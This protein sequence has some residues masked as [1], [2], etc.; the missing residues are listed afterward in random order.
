MSQSAILSLAVLKVNWET[1]GKDYLENFVPFLLECIRL[2][3]DDLVSLPDLQS[4]VKKRFDLEIPQHAIE[5]LLRRMAKRGY[6]QTRRK[7]Y[8]RK[9]DLLD[10]TGFREA[11]QR[12]LQ[13]HDELLRSLISFCHTAHGVGWTEKDAEEALE[14]YLEHGLIPLIRGMRQGTL[15][16][17]PEHPPKSARYLVG[18]Y[19]RHLQETHS[20][21]LG[22]L[23][24]VLKGHMLASA[25][26]LNETSQSQRK[27]C[28]TAVYFDTSFLIYALG[29]AGEARRDPCLEV[30]CLLLETG[31]EIKCFEHTV[32]EIRGIL[33]AIAYR[34]GRRQFSELYGP[35]VEYFLSQGRTESDIEVLI[36]RLEQDLEGLGLSVVEKPPYAVNEHVIDERALTEFLSQRVRYFNNTTPARDRDVASISAVMRLR[37]GRDAFL[38]ENCRAVFVTTNTSLASA[39]RDFAYGSSSAPNGTVPP[40]LIDQ[41]FT[42]TLWLKRPMD[43]PDLPK[44]RIIA[45]CY[46]ATQ[47]SESL[48]RRYMGEID[49]LEKDRK[50]TAE[51]SYLLRCSYEAKTTL[52]DLTIGEEDVFTQGTVPEILQLLRAQIQAEPRAELKAE[53]ERREQAQAELSAHLAKDRYRVARLRQRAQKWARFI[54]EC[55]RY[56]IV[57]GLLI[58]II[59]TSPWPL[60]KFLSSSYIVPVF[61]VML[62]IGYLAGL[63]WGTTVTA[64]LN[65]VGVD[66]A[67]VLTRALMALSG[68]DMLAKPGQTP[69]KYA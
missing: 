21:A 39:A 33:K 15:L 24:T 68:D 38:V 51:D 54:T 42:N 63:M 41:E 50:V 1:H 67:S 37:R 18:S 20:G 10:N 55:L 64:L 13:M 46:A 22:Y 53:T 25:V 23:E 12:V 35:S 4:D 17:I 16:P 57:V 60:P 31:A 48:W 56:A 34:I 14:T 7:V 30:L 45:D 9:A 58:G 11:Q 2:S 62:L 8:W 47:P 26:F 49:V 69:S 5:T 59:S 29:Y 61:Q 65:R 32:D 6:L 40:V 28:D 66:I 52:M 3:A 19:I 43:F 27:F 44:K 36:G